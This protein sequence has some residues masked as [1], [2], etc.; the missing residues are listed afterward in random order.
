M[1]RVTLVGLMKIELRDGRTIRLCDGGW[2]PWGAEVYRSSHDQ[3][4]M[5]GSMQ[6]FEEGV[7]DEVPAFQLTF[8]PVSTAAAADLS[9]PG[10]QGSRS[11]IWIAEINASTG[12]IIGTPDLQFDGMIDRTLLRIGARKR[13]LDI[14]FVS[15]SERLFTIV[16]GNSLSTA[17]HKSVFPGELGEDNATGLG[18]GV[19]WGAEAQ[20]GSNTQS[21]WTIIPSSAANTKALIDGLFA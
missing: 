7:G 15:T 6:S 19:A 9:A 11:R 12:T 2:V 14:E 10:M 18:V 21:S 16:E 4:G 17:F 8:L 20:P 13:E 3:F 1:D 5:I